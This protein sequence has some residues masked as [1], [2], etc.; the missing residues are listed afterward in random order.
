MKIQNLLLALVVVSGACIT[1]SESFLLDTVGNVVGGTVATVAATALQVAYGPV[2]LAVQLACAAFQVAVRTALSVAVNFV[3]AVLAPKCPEG[4]V[5][6]VKPNVVG[7]GGKIEFQ[8]VA[9]RRVRRQATCKIVAA[10]NTIIDGV[11]LALKNFHDVIEDGVNATFSAGILVIKGTT[12]KD[13]SPAIVEFTGNLTSIIQRAVNVYHGE[14]GKAKKVAF[15]LLGDGAENLLAGLLDP[16]ENAINT[17]V[18]ILSDA[19]LKAINIALG[20]ISTAISVPC[21]LLG[22]K[23]SLNILSGLTS[24][25]CLS[26]G[27]GALLNFDSKVSAVAADASV[28]GGTGGSVSITGRLSF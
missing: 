23:L 13:I 16:L 12:C 19:L 7:T 15:E 28:S 2:L 21:S 5:V 17:A 3:G 4:T 10:A 22:G 8:V 24:T 14:F 9:E 27:L 1:I 11:S 25:G 20:T 26:E 6:D 18:C